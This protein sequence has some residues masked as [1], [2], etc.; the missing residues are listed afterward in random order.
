VDQNAQVN[1]DATVDGQQANTTNQTTQPNS[2]KTFTQE[3][4]NAIV[5]KRLSQVEK[6]FANI[7]VSEYQELKSLKEQQETEAALK[8]QEFDKV[9]GQVKSASE[10]KIAALTR[11]LE[12]IK[13]DGALIAE[14]S[15][16]K[17]V[18]PDKVAAL[19]RNN[20]KLGA[21][22]TVEV[23]DT[24]G[25]VRYD[26]DKAKPLGIS[27][28]VE[29]FLQSNPYFVAAAPAGSGAKPGF[30]QETNL[31]KINVADLDMRKPEHRELYRKMKATQN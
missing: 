19:L 1:V 4:V 31:T 17:A 10:Q 9:L 18:A 5:T 22:G 20:L 25:Q 23:L 12:T 21:D 28:L 15:A 27:D 7:D 30:G 14:A 29:E 3:E 24:D 6:K 2:E 13:I 11:E 8:R 26:A 16:R